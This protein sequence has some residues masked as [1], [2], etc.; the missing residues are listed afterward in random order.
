VVGIGL[1]T[2][3]VLLSLATYQHTLRMP[4]SSDA[5]FLT[6]QNRFMQDPGGLS[7][8]WTADFFEGAITHGRPYMSGYYRPVTNTVFW[9]E[10]ALAGRNDLIYHLSQLFIHA[11]NA[12]LIALLCFR[13]RKDYLAAGIAGLFFVLHPVHAFAAT[14]VAARADVLFPVF[15][16]LA[17]LAFD[18]GVRSKTS[19]AMSWWMVLTVALY[20]SA[21]MSKEMGI[22]LPAVLVL[23]VVYRHFESAVPLRKLTLTVPVWIA[24]V[25]YLVWRFVVLQLPTPSVGYGETLA[26]Y[27]LVLGAVK[28]MLIQISRIALPLGAEYP[29][30]NP[31]LINY[32]ASPFSDPLTYLAVAVVLAL[33]VIALLWRWSPFT[34]FW[35]GFFLITFSPLLK[36]DS[37]AGTLGYTIILA[38][39]RWIYLPFVAAAAI[40]GLGVA[41][42][43]RSH[44]RR[45]PRM[46]AALVGI[47]ICLMLGR[48]AAA[49]AGRHEDP[50]AQL[51]RLYLIPEERLSRLQQANKLI[52]YAQWVATPMGNLAEAEERARAATELAPDSPI[53]ATALANVLMHAEKWQGVIDAL[54]PWLHPS[55]EELERYRETNYRVAD[56]LN[57][58]SKRIPYL[59]AQAQ[60]QLGEVGRAMDLL[61]ESVRR[62]FDQ[63]RVEET[64]LEVYARD[65][66]PKCSGT[67]DVGSC[68]ANTVLP[69]ATGWNPPFDAR[70]CS[71]WADAVRD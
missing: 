1:V 3:F 40:L 45:V 43:V 28:G 6:Y 66:P 35:S 8:V 50:F 14:D 42:L 44:P 38:Q 9:I 30:L 61:C 68:V 55:T 70:T 65:G 71:V 20:L 51:R 13:I 49:H 54:T 52:L 67:Q 56:D 62:D 16:V 25:G 57:R 32:A 26:T 41:K 60:A 10:H 12:L 53:T 33:A 29:E 59:L 23:L 58:V 19:Q 36:V 39:E 17:L 31:Q 11:L 27:E 2:G 21:V 15:Y 47:I 5:Q 4:L 37:I 24:F 63:A 18:S 7:Q 34:A 48:T 69:D 46:S 64:L 22:T